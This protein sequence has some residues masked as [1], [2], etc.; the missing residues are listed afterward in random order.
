MQAVRG[1][2]PVRLV[3]PEGSKRGVVGPYHQ[4]RIPR[5]YILHSYST[6]GMIPDLIQP[7]LNARCKGKLLPETE[8]KSLQVAVCLNT[9]FEQRLEV[10]SLGGI[11]YLGNSGMNKKK[12]RSEDT[13][14]DI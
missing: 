13:L 10:S 14:M 4:V 1:P 12:S 11:W 9:G 6:V 5:R 7:R 3:I 8:H 2:C